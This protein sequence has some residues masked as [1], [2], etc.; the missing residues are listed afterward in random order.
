M[1]VK[2][3][4]RPLVYPIPTVLVGAQVD[5]RPNFATVGQCGIMGVNPPLVYVS[6]NRAHFTT[7]G[8]LAQGTYSI[9]VPSIDMLA[10]TDYCGIVSGRE[11]DKSE[12]F[13]VFYGE[14]ETAPMIEE[15]PVNLECRVV[16][17]FSIEHRQIFVAR[18]L[19]AYINAEYVTQ[20]GE[21]QRV[22]DLTRLAPIVYA[23][24]NR[25]YSIGE[26]IGVG[27]REGKVFQNSDT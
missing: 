13:R 21:R 7:E 26:P 2:L 27:Y 25:Y 3:G 14:F 16:N 9:N 19:Q 17:E 18:V 20:D 6:L 22:A 11:I 15:C 8:I 5:G 12:L 24:D 23:L 1:K 10:V 4:P